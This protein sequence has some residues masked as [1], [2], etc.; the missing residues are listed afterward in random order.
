MYTCVKPGQPPPDRGAGARTR[1]PENS[2]RAHF[3]A[4][5]LQTP[6]KF[7]VKT[8][9]ERKKREEGKKS[10]KFCPP[11]FGASTLGASTL[12]GPTPWWT[13]NST[14]KNWPKSNWPK[15]K[16][17]EVEIGRSRKKKRWPK[18]KLAEVDRAQTRNT[19]RGG[20]QEE[21]PGEE[22][23]EETPEEAV[24][25]GNTKKGWEEETPEKGAAGKRKHPRK[26]R[27]KGDA[28]REVG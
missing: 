16:L 15:S 2:K 5:A 26:H 18:S 17:A 20:W 7:H 13:K 10:A 3:R 24:K 9:R 11:P 22:W 14:S 27:K 25:R 1:Q 23:N 12:W 4:P 28:K 19:R 6:P 8:P 21:T